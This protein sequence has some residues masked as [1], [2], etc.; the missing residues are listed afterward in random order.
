MARSIFNRTYWSKAVR[1][2]RGGTERRRPTTALDFARL[3][4]AQQKRDR[5]G[6]VRLMT[7]TGERAA[8]RRVSRRKKVA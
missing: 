8:K 4:A 6:R 1:T 7:W 2:L 3:E 5:K